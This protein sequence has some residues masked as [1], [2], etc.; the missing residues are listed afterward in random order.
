MAL[1]ST[2]IRD[3][4]CFANT[5]ASPEDDW[6]NLFFED[7]GPDGNSLGNNYFPFEY[8]NLATPSYF[9]FTV[10]TGFVLDSMRIRWR[11]T[12]G[13]DGS[14]NQAFYTL[15]PDQIIAL[16]ADAQR[17][18][19]DL[20]AAPNN[21]FL[22]GN[23]GPNF[24]SD[25]GFLYDLQVFITPTCDAATNWNAQQA[26]NGTGLGQNDFYSTH[27]EVSTFTG[28]TLT[29]YS[30]YIKIYNP[31][32]V[33][34]TPVEKI[35]P[36]A[37][38]LADWLL[39]VENEAGA[40]NAGNVWLT[41]ESPSGDVAT[42]ILALYD[43]DDNLI[44]PDA[45]GIFQL[46][47]LDAMA[48]ETY[49]VVADY[50][51]CERDSLLVFYGWDCSGYPTDLTSLSDMCIDTTC[52]IVDPAGAS[53]SLAVTELA[54][55]P[56]DPTD[57]SAG[58][59]G[60]DR[61]NACEPFPVEI[62]VISGEQ[63]A[64]YDAAV[65]LFNPSGGGTTGLE[66]IPGTAFIEYPVGTSPRP[67]DASVEAVLAGDPDAAF[68]DFVLADI[69]PANFDPEPLFG[70]DSIPAGKNQFILRLEYATNCDL[71]SGE[72]LR[73]RVFGDQSCGEPATGNRETV[74]GFPIRINGV[75]PS[76]VVASELRMEELYQ[77][78]GNQIGSIQLALQKFGTNATSGADEIV[79][80]LPEYAAFDASTPVVCDTDGVPNGAC[81]ADLNPSVLLLSDGRTELRW[82]MAAGMANLDS[83]LLTFGID[84]GDDTECGASSNLI[85]LQTISPIDVFCPTLDGGVGGLCESFV[86]TGMVTD[87]FRIGKPILEVIPMFSAISCENPTD[88]SFTVD[89]TNTGEDL[90]AGEGIQVFVYEDVDGNGAVSMGDPL[91][92]TFD[93][94]GGL[95]NGATTMI[96]GQVDLSDFTNACGLVYRIESCACDPVEVSNS[97]I[98]FDAA[99]PDVVICRNR[100]V[101]VGCVEQQTGFTFFWEPVNGG[102]AVADPTAAQPMIQIDEE[103]GTWEYQL[104]VTFPGGCVVTDIVEIELLKVGCGSNFPWNGQD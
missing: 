26:D 59:Y 70:I 66:Y 54:D 25:D 35:R 103:G 50:V 86:N 91:L 30:N 51:A 77:A 24:P 97:A 2:K 5:A 73:A 8:R 83:L 98:T 10:P 4:S 81:P 96:A 7:I 15:V 61:V 29:N 62:Q 36:G 49:Q 85:E 41:F 32:F 90:P 45:N 76:Y 63:G 79:V 100:P 88:F 58:D 52:L 37:T 39:E 28:A 80:T 14:D 38:D 12:A 55:T 48:L 16:P 6:V 31:P 46:G 40:S 93:D 71:T 57:P 42:S 101:Q 102:P 74:L 27:Y 94:F 3:D 95:P 68:F 67:I 69:D 19:V 17:I 33:E 47:E 64:I 23:G 65:R 13:T 11:R 18:I 87:S 60:S 72:R 22:A 9:E 20:T 99:G 104:T 1:Y 82:Q 78:C 89:L 34:A 75:D 92:G 56:A 21:G 53:V 43:P 44:T 84:I